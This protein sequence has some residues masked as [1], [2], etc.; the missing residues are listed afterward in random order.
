VT[1]PYG[2][3]VGYTE[4]DWTYGFSNTFNYKN[5]TLSV[6]FDG[7][8]GGL[9]Y[10]STNQKMWWGG[11][12]PGTV[13]QYRDDANNGES[14]YT[15]QGVKVVSGDVTYD[16][17]GNITGDTRQYAPND[18]PVN[19]ISFMKTTSNAHNE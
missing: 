2:R 11:I 19:Y 6:L 4:P 3:Y 5:F 10:S 8:I 15:G 1:D 12:S 7:R 16:S 13:N 14:T 18:I 17:N 9:M